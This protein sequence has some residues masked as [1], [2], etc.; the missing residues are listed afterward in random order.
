LGIIAAAFSQRAFAQ[1]GTAPPT[2]AEQLRSKATDLEKAGKW[3]E[4]LQAWCK[5][6]S[7]DRTND[8]AHKHLQLCLRRLMQSQRPG[9]KSLREKVLTLSH[10]QALKLYG[11]VLTTLQS[12]YVDRERV[13]PARLFQQGLDEFLISINDVH[14]RTQ[15]MPDVRDAAVRV[16][17]SRLREY[18]ATRAIDNVA[19]AVELLTQVAA[20][21]KRDLH[22]AKTSVVVLEFIG[23]ACNSLDE[24]TSYL[25]PGDLAAEAQIVSES[26]VAHDILRGGIGYL[27]ITHFRDTTPAEVD[28]AIAAMR[29]DP[30]AMNL[31]VI[32]MDL[33]GNHGGV[34]TAAVQV[35]GRFIP[36]GVIATTQGQL[37]EF[38]QIH[39]GG[40]KMNV[41][42][43]PLVVLVD[44]STASAA[45]VLAGAFRDHQ[46][47]T[48]VGTSTFGKGSIQRVLQ[49]TTA[50]ETDEHGKVRTRTGGIRIT[51]ARFYSPNGQ[52]INGA[53]IAPH[54]SEPDKA[55][56]LEAALE[57]A[58]RFVS[59]MMPM[60]SPAVTPM[61]R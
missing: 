10:S 33:R 35:A 14:F 4:A 22:I 60:T 32:I 3:E 29:M 57:Q 48:L 58:G 26:S 59:D 13:S 61:I 5:V 44:G 24:Y 53:G 51:L 28:S 54:V 1:T 39:N 2:A 42:D 46:R 36:D 16:F 9:D 21:A 17:Q 34:F 55:R 27:R 38:N 52:A 41:I 8:E 40:A 18:M 45:E 43:L 56:Q 37:D 50:E 7:L 49:F 6:Y 15:H 25:S 20:T 23:G 31:R 11:E 12:A 19:D 30:R 47:A